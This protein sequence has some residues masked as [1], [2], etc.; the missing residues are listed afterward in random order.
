M[1]GSKLGGGPAGFSMATQNDVPLAERALVLATAFN[2]KDMKCAR[3]HD[4][5]VNPFSQQNLFAMAAML[6]RSPLKLPG[7][8][9][10]PAGPNGERS[11]LITVSL[12]PGATIDPVWPFASETASSPELLEAWSQLLQNP[13]DTRE[14]LALHLTHPVQS[15]FAEV[16][17]NR[18]WERLFG[19]GLMPQSDR[20]DNAHRE[21]A[22]ILAALAQQHIRDGYDLKKTAAVLL[23][24][25]AWQRQTAADDSPLLPLFGALPIRR[26][27]AEQMVDSLYVAAG[28]QFDA[29][30]LTLDPEGRRPDSSFLNLGVPRR[31]WHFCSLSNE[32]DR[33][34]LALP[35]AQ[36][37]YDL[38]TVFGWRDSRPSSQ[39]S[40]PTEATVLQSLTLA[41]GSAGHRLIQL[42]DGSA[43]T[44]QV[45][46]AD[47]IDRLTESLFLQILTRRPDSEESQLIEQELNAG[48]ADRI[49]ADAVVPDQ[50]VIK[51]NQ[52][53]WSNH[54]NP[55]ATRIKQ[56]LELAARA[57]DPPSVRLTP[58]WRIR[59]EDV[60]WAL[61]NSPE[62]AFIP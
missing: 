1:K 24:S 59:A 23:E 43:L 29:E 32:R 40:R 38:L 25:T 27:T 53:S 19:R 57:G 52:V 34:A 16:I 37:I 58:E 3:C 14:Q 50:P 48:F 9:T 18:L 54:L 5:P 28:K 35:V 41:N 45:I 11:Q 42:S 44:E 33:P 20:W 26:L 12:E 47:A 13:A 60:V 4:S 62:F 56:E 7:T 30:V 2:A 6:N 22:E 17:V 31:A 8:S 15:P 49:I 36:T 39:S 55:E 21:N 61:M 10:V 51:R 46:Q